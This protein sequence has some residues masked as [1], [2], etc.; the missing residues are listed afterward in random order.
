MPKPL[1]PIGNIAFLERQLAWLGRHGVD[2]VVLSLGY[3]PDAFVEHFPEGRC[4]AVR[5]R[6]AVEKEP[7]GTAGGIRYA[8]DQAGIDERFVV[9]NGDVLTELDLTALVRFHDERGADATIH[10]ARV[11]DPSAFGVVPT[12]DDGEVKAFVEKPAPGR[13]PTDWINAGTYVLEPSVLAGIPPGLTV[14][15][16]RET[17]PHMLDHPRRLFAYPSD[18]YWLDIGTPEKYLEAHA[19]VLAGRLGPAGLPAG[20][21]ERAPRVWCEGDV[22]IA[23][24]ARVEAPVLLGPGSDIGPR[25]TVS[26][27]VLGAGCVVEQDARVS[28][29]VLLAGARLE[30]GA[31]VV[32]SV[33]GPGGVLERGA[34]ASD[35]TIVGAAAVVAERSR[36]AGARLQVPGTPAA[37]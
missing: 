12:A 24:A 29:S 37:R 36:V 18:A 11:P 28:R 9:C 20:A 5:V 1:L 2:D 32:D 13:A 27:S 17:F 35:H 30:A 14:S 22:T 6:Y 21:V 16:E 10:L 3:L 15:I 4:G 19:D 31:Q 7:L 26:G 23:A 33:I 25:A 34:V 8:A